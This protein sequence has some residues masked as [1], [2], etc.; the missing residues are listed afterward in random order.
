MR[1]RAK[2][3]GLAD[4]RVSLSHGGVCFLPADQTVEYFDV[5]QPFEKISVRLQPHQV[6]EAVR[7][8]CG[9]TAT[10]RA[11]VLPSDVTGPLIV[12]ARDAAFAQHT[13]PLLFESL[14]A[15]IVYSFVMSSWTL[16]GGNPAPE[17]PGAL[18]AARQHRVM[19]FIEQN[20]E[21]PITLTEAASL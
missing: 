11:G 20:I 3:D 4:G 18:S 21:R 12:A 16:I 13:W 6:D 17:H 5:D 2:L 8:I 1:G 10:I 14:S 7:A 9:S 19:Q 15:A